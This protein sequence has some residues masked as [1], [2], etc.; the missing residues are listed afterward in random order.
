MKQLTLED[1]VGSFD[2]K[3]ISTSEKFLNQS[4]EQEKLKGSVFDKKKAHVKYK[5]SN[6]RF[7]DV[8]AMIPSHAKSSDELSSKEKEDPK[9]N[10][11]IDY[12]TAIWR[13]NR[14]ENKEFSWDEAEELCKKH[15]EQKKSIAMRILLE[16][17]FEPKFV[18]K[19]LK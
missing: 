19:Y 4:Q 2:Y 9:F 1:V 14:D 7:A 6:K 5:P 8:R 12:V 3:A 15:R 13:Y 10:M 17:G 18:T 16:D 11:F